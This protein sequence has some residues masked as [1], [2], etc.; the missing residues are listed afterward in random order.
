MPVNLEP[1]LKIHFSSLRTEITYFPHATQRENLL[2]TRCNEKKY[3][4]L[5]GRCSYT[6]VYYNPRFARVVN[7]DTRS[8]TSPSAPLRNV[9]FQTMEFSTKTRESNIIFQYIMYHLILEDN[10]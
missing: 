6:R 4:Q 3:T 9:L 5:S 10:N 2:S 1:I 8:G 7:L